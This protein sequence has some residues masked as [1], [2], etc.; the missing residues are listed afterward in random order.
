MRIAIH[1]R[2]SIERLFETGFPENTAVISF[3][4][5]LMQKLGNGYSPVDYSGKTDAVFQIALEDIEFVTVD[6]P[7][8]YEGYFEEVDALAEFIL[9]AHE[10]GM[11]MICQCDYGQSRSAGCAAAIM[12]YFY[13]NGIA[14]FADSRYIPNQMVFNK[15]LD[16]LI[17]KEEI[18]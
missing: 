1:S 2:K 6:E 17:N 11:N 3:Y 9:R 12:Q 15:V 4:D 10:Q 16:A 13:G 8:D 14:V 18:K 5:P 7:A